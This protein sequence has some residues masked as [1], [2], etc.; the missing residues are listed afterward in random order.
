MRIAVV[1]TS[2]PE[3]DGDP[4]GH[5][6]ASEVR[7]LEAA[8]HDVLVIAPT[9]GG[10]FGWPG[11]SAR[12][13]ERPL[14][15]IEA[16]GFVTRASLELAR[17]RPEKVIAHWV[18]PSGT[19]I[20]TTGLV[21]A[22]RAVL[23]LVSHG[24]DVRLLLAMPRLVRERTVRALVGRAERWRFV[25]TQL[26]EQLASVLPSELARDVR[27]LSVVA[28]SPLGPLE[29]VRED[30]AKRRDS[31]QGRRL[32][33]CAGRLVA[34]KRIDK[35]IDWVAT[36]RS[37]DAGPDPVLV[38]LGDGPERARLERVAD[39]WGIDARF[40]GKAERRE[41]LAW[42]A[43]ADAVLHASTAEGLS[44]VVREAELLGTPVRVL[45]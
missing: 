9:Q 30:A 28:A 13:R 21:L 16:S 36:E 33:V 44:T 35:I 5:F 23:E 17:I 20:A 19:P 27:S 12:I 3:S 14:R 2:Y 1:T 26:L 10:A 7:E 32:F 4:A 37:G 29:D 41:T 43:A 24:A 40:L 6:V 42:I 34:S 38:V 25:S 31:V 39:R 45:V 22:R 8:G 15:A 11:V 18:V